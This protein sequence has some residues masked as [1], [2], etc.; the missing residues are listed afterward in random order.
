MPATVEYLRTAREL[1]EKYGAV[2]IFDEVITGFR[3]RAGSA[4]A[5]YGIQPDLT[6][7]G[8]IIGGGMPLAAVG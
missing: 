5:L 1:T 2:L 3:F 6:T 8:K 4:G 7:M